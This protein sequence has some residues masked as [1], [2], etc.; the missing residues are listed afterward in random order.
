MHPSP[1]ATPRGVG[2]L[3]CATRIYEANRSTAAPDTWWTPPAEVATPARQAEVE[4]SE[5]YS[6][7]QFV[8]LK[9]D[10]LRSMLDLPGL[11]LGSEMPVVLIMGDQDRVSVPGIAKASF[12][13]IVAPNKQYVVM[14][15]AGHDSNAATIAAE[16]AALGSVS[17]QK[18]GF[19]RL[20]EIEADAAPTA[21]RACRAVATMR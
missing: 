9:G 21:H 15:N 3:R 18:I 7:L 1:W 13:T 19:L 4:S 20:E 11:G 16:F 17:W 8:G 10:G 14:P 12:D 2:V 6:Y 5:D